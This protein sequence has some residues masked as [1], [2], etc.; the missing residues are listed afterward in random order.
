MSWNDDYDGTIRI[1]DHAF[2]T[3]T[4]SGI[5]AALEADKT[6]NSTIEKVKWKDV[7]IDPNSFYEWWEMQK[8]IETARR[9]RDLAQL[10][11]QRKRV[12][13]LAKL[14]EEERKILGVE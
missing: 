6:L 3:G 8:A 9:A 14:T 12:I 2:L 4:L 7:G 11:N 13:I 5:V 10:D 1:N